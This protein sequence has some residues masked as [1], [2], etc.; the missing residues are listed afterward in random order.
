MTL[1]PEDIEAIADLV[2][3]KLRDLPTGPELVDVTTLARILGVS[4]DYVY[5][6]ARRLGGIK[7]G[8]GPRL[9]GASTLRRP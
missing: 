5:E 8:T 4:T 1:D 6:H 3:R 7:A 9:A 2:V